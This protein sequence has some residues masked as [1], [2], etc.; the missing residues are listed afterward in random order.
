[1]APTVKMMLSKE[2][3]LV[4]YIIAYLKSQEL[5]SKTS[6]KIGFGYFRISVNHFMKC[7]KLKR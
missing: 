5:I 7:S 3:V 6:C 4:F 2:L 1:M